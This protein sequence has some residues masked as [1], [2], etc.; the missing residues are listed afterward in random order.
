MYRSKFKSAFVLLLFYFILPQ[1]FSVY[2]GGIVPKEDFTIT[3]MEGKYKYP[4]NIRLRKGEEYIVTGETENSYVIKYEMVKGI[5]L[6]IHVSRNKV[7]YIETTKAEERERKRREAVEQFEEEQKAK[8]LV[9]IGDYWVTKKSAELWSQFVDLKRLRNETIKLEK[10]NEKNEADLLAYRGDIARLSD[11]LVSLQ[12]RAAPLWEWLKNN[13]VSES[14]PEDKIRAYNTKV[15]EYNN[16]IREHSNK[17][18]AI[19]KKQKSY[20][21]KNKVIR[22]NTDKYQM[23][24]SAY[25]KK[26]TKFEDDL[27]NSLSNAQGEQRRFL[28]SMAEEIQSLSK[29]LMFSIIQARKYRGGTFVKGVINDKVD[30]MF[31]VDTGATYV[32]ISTSMAKQLQLDIIS[33]TP[34]ENLRLADGSVQNVPV[35]TLSSISLG[36]VKQN[37]VKAAVMETSPNFTPLLGM[38]FLKHFNWR[39]EG[40]NKIVFEKLEIG[41]IRQEE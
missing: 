12:K 27:M 17:V 35:V 3:P 26:F 10:S 19:E 20:E 30:A 4:E 14:S 32:T 37:Q 39:F 22:Y 6:N 11:Q 40:N 2:A 38:S 34:R 36:G 31:M 1:A 28:S 24:K 41:N 29:E 25:I 5:F 33:K 8:G 16:L 9:N 15:W 21:N 23:K 7:E 18:L 13:K